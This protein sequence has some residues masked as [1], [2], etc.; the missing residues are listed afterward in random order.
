MKQRHPT[1]PH[2]HRLG[3]STL[4]AAN[5]HAVVSDLLASRKYVSAA[6]GR[7]QFCTDGRAARLDHASI[8]SEKSCSG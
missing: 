7:E 2:L 4:Y 3:N 5:M 6:Q 8:W 1:E